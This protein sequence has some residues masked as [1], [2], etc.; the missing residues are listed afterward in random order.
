MEFVR[1]K[2]P[3]L[4]THMEAKKKLIISLT[5]GIMESAWTFTFTGSQICWGGINRQ[6]KI[7]NRLGKAMFSFFVIRFLNRLS[8]I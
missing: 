3:L 1:H 4:S 7:Q 2:I 6:Q 8:L 5:Q